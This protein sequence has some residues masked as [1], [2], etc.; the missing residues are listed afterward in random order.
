MSQFNAIQKHLINTI[1]KI[2]KFLQIELRVEF[3]VI[4]YKGQ[5]FIIAT[6]QPDDNTYTIRQNGIEIVAEDFFD[7]TKL[8]NVSHAKTTGFIPIDGKEGLRGFGTS[9]C[10]FVLF[11]EHNFCFVEFK[12]NA[13]D[14]SEG[15]KDELHIIRKIR[16][17]RKKA[18]SQLSN[19]ID[20]FDNQLAKN[21]E[22]L[23][24]EAYVCTP[25]SYPKK[26]TA[27]EE[28]EVAFLEKYGFP[29]FEENSKVCK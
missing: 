15:D 1:P 23:G 16:K 7:R 10:D 6:I 8:F 19:T 22:G 11:D 26:N 9:H 20:W 2:S 29:L 25:E 3:S 5:S 21:Y 28:L 14:I 12:L 27:W 13:E 4:D 18:I 24:L 17:N